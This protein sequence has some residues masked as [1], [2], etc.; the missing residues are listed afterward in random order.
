MTDD[1]RLYRVLMFARSKVRLQARPD[2]DPMTWRFPLELDGRSALVVIRDVVS[3][4]ARHLT[5]H[6]GL[7][8]EVDVHADSEE[9]ARVRAVS[10]ASLH[11]TALTVTTRAPVDP[12]TVVLV[13]EFTPGK[14]TDLDFTQWQEVALPLAKA[15]A[16]GEAVS[17]VQQALLNLRDPTQRQP[18]TLAAQTYAA[19]MREVEPVLR[20][21]CYG[22]RARRWIARCGVCWIG[23]R[24]TASGD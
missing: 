5:V 4:D 13:Y 14:T 15:P 24:R 18:I 2:D 3:D 22:Q 11:I 1:Q 12:L 9:D 6:E 20:S 7:A 10:L 17:R 23:T 21:S 19:G 8:I 16:P